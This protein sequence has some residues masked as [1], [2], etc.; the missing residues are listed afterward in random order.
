MSRRVNESELGCGLQM[1][2]LVC[3]N[4]HDRGCTLHKILG[5]SAVEVLVTKLWAQLAHYLPIGSTSAQTW[6]WGIRSLMC[7]SPKMEL[8]RKQKLPLFHTQAPQSPAIKAQP[9]P[10]VTLRCH[11]QFCGVSSNFIVQ[12][13]PS[14]SKC[15]RIPPAASYPKL[16]AESVVIMWGL[17]SGLA[18]ILYACRAYMRELWMR[19]PA[20]VQSCPG[21]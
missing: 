20:H 21:Y 4:I 2:I 10:I 14:D 17:W 16:R 1:S 3:V 11:P 15:N 7:E 6:N 9:C 8:K 18:S 13:Q 19:I 5:M 12:Y